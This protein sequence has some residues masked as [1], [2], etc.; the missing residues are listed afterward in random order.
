MAVRTTGFNRRLRRGIVGWVVVCVLAAGVMVLLLKQRREM[1]RLREAI[2]R[3]RAAEETRPRADMREGE[4]WI[5]DAEA[6]KELARLRTDREALPRLRAEVASLRKSVD[7]TRPLPGRARK[8]DANAAPDISKELA[9]AAAW[10]NRGYET[11]ADAIE[12]ALWAAAGGDTEVLMKSLVFEESAKRKAEALFAS[13][14]EDVRR[15]YRGP[16]ELVAFMTA[17]DVPLEGARIIARADEKAEERKIAVQLKNAAG[18]VR[19]LQIGVRKMADG[20]RLV[21]PESAVERYAAG[22][23]APTAEAVQVGP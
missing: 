13:L 17:K 6:E 5:H 10:K 18:S 12:T 7:E 4:I 22:L 1:A 21:M 11:P 15:R 8:N 23:K 14:P 2:A 16:E 20:W 3:E 19:Q 9:P